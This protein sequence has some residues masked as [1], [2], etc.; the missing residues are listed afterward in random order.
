MGMIYSVRSDEE[1]A[2][3]NEI[4]FFSTRAGAEHLVEAIRAN[5]EAFG[6]R[7]A[8]SA[9]S[10]RVHEHMIDPPMESLMTNPLKPPADQPYMAKNPEAMQP[11]WV[12]GPKGTVRPAPMDENA[13]PMHQ[14]LASW[15]RR[16]CKFAN[17]EG[18]GEA[19]E[20]EEHPF[21]ACMDKVRRHHID[22]DDP[23]A[24]CAKSK[25]KEEGTTHWRGK[26]KDK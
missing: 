13:S 21:K 1:Y 6:E 2:G 16:H 23:E 26:E 20:G 19:I 12:P 8:Y 25:D 24:F 17:A 4:A 15:V 7:T 3:D 9:D 14:P 10:V 22:V 11:G 5:P 18:M